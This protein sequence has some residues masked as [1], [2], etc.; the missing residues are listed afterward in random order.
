VSNRRS[1]R[2]REGRRRPCQQHQSAD[3]VT[4]PRVGESGA[5]YQRRRRQ[6]QQQRRRWRSGEGGG[7]RHDDRRPSCMNGHRLLRF[8]PSRGLLRDSER[9]K[10]PSPRGSLSLCAGG[11]SPAALSGSRG[12]NPGGPAEPAQPVPAPAVPGPGGGVA[13]G[14]CALAAHSRRFRVSAPGTSPPAAAPLSR[15]ARPARLE[16]SCDSANPESG[17]ES[18]SRTRNPDSPPRPGPARRETRRDSARPVSEADGPIAAPTPIPQRRAGRVGRGARGRRPA[19]RAPRPRA[20]CAPRAPRPRAPPPKWASRVTPQPGRDPPGPALP[21]RRLRSSPGPGR[22]LPCP[23]Q[24]PQDCRDKA[25]LGQHYAFL[26]AL[27]FPA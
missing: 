6:Q 17:S 23:P 12:A 21:D 18:G 8:P 9:D 24:V 7:S 14:P 10:F 3:C 25:R 15:R 27:A 2:A 5:G 11:C 19:P 4:A 20:K 22:P 1:G 16:T 26:A 13:R